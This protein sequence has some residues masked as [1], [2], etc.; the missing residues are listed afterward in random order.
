MVMELTLENLSPHKRKH[1]VSVRVP[2]SSLLPDE[3]TLHVGDFPHRM[4][5]VV[6]G[7]TNGDFTTLHV[8]ADMDG[9]ELL[10]GG[11]SLQP[12]PEATP[13]FVMHPWVYDD[14]EKLVPR[15]QVL[16]SKSD[17]VEW[18]L[19]DN[20][21]AR[22]RWWAKIRTRNGFIMEWFADVYCNDPVVDI[23][24]KV[25]WSDRRTS[26]PSI[27]ADFI[28]IETG[29]SVVFDFARN[30]GILQGQKN[31]QGVY[32]HILATNMIFGDGVAIPFSGVMLCFKDGA[33]N[34]TNEGIHESI[35]N[36]QAA[37]SG[38]IRG[39]AKMLNGEWL[40]G[41]QLPRLVSQVVEE[42]EEDAWAMFAATQNVPRGFLAAR[43]FGCTA[44][45]GQP[46]DQEDFAATKG[47]LAILGRPRQTYVL[48]HSVQADALRGFNHYEEN[49]KPL[50][51]ANHPRWTTNNGGT[52][53]NTSVSPDR[54]GKTPLPVP[55]NGW[56]GYDNQHRSQNNLAAYLALC[57]DPIMLDQVKHMITTDKA[58]YR[59][60]YPMYGAEPAR[61]QGRPMGTWAN[62]YSAT[63]LPELKE[64][65]VAQIRQTYW[66][67]N[68]LPV[69]PVAPLAIVPV[70]NRKP[71]RINGQLTQSVCMWEHGL[72]IVGFYLAL[73]AFKFEGDDLL[74]IRTILDRLS[75][76]LMTCA[77]FRETSGSAFETMFVSDM[78]WVGD[79]QLP[80]GGLVRGN[81]ALS[82]AVGLDGVG[83]WVRAGLRVAHEY[84]GTAEPVHLIDDPSISIRRAEWSA[85]VRP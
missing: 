68:L 72:A 74:M 31:K 60:K 51:L 46:G 52:H 13:Q 67:M 42:E 2:K 70:D 22:Q 63:G 61:G 33:D 43:P 78:A 8:H 50:D 18:K 83:L 75:N 36:L 65:A 58:D 38:P 53:W 69:G 45:P 56:Y 64:L 55:A 28:Q 20:S 40:A 54:L 76:L 1:W 85:A 79:G 62:L 48:Q 4:M 3:M 12:H 57:D 11:L 32:K 47:T 34:L 30:L 24:G 5:R 19:I 26:L 17:L 80:P 15:L 82:L 9:H 59:R 25:V 6:L 44:T 14:I 16:G 37:G 84:T 21:R 27:T 49:G 10:T 35:Q 66:A 77:T 7:A 81:P 73:R 41:G 29:E 23:W 39:V 71:V